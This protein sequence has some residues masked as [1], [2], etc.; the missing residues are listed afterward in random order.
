MRRYLSKINRPMIR[1]NSD[2]KSKSSARTVLCF[3]VPFP[4]WT[5]S[6]FTTSRQI[7]LCRHTAHWNIRRTLVGLG[8]RL[9][10]R[11]IWRDL[12]VVPVF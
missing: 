7:L 9:E 10:Q 5:Y 11:S 6:H 3:A 12:V 2:V 1:L 8:G 4:Y